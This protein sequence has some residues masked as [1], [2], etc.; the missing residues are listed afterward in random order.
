[1]VEDNENGF[2]YNGRNWNGVDS[3]VAGKRYAYAFGWIYNSENHDNAKLVVNETEYN[4]PMDVSES[5]NFREVV[6]VIDL[7]VADQDGNLSINGTPDIAVTSISL[8]KNS[9][10]LTVGA[11]E[12]L[13]ATVLPEDAT[14]KN[15]TWTSSN[16]DVATVEDGLVK[17]LAAG[18][19]TIKATSA[20]IDTIFAECTVT[21]N[22]PYIPSPI[23]PTPSPDPDK[24]EF[25]KDTELAPDAPIDGV[26]LDN[27]KSEPLNAPAI[28]TEAEKQAIE[29]G[30]GARVWIEVTYTDESKISAED[31]A[32]VETV[33]KTCVF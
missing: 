3:F 17:A 2:T 31:M 1:M 32:K 33:V 8:N 23:T 25:V 4:S 6:F 24:D 18:T 29:N 19:A 11:T 10:T 15:V 7:G 21:V 5:Q 26:S 13:T 20:S 16:T 9:T 22:N 28:F 14:N 30:S 27:E 12:T